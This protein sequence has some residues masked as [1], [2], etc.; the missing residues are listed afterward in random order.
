MDICDEEQLFSGFKSTRDN[1]IPRH[2]L[3][4][5]YVND[6]VRLIYFNIK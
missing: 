5:Q 1:D 2:T 6:W 3:T 4:L